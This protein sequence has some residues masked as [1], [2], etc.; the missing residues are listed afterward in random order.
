MTLEE[1]IK[2]CERQSYEHSKCAEEHK[3]L[4]EWLKELQELKQ[5]NCDNTDKTLKD[6]CSNT[7]K[8]LKRYPLC[9]DCIKKGRGGHCRKPDDVDCSD[10]EDEEEYK[11]K[12]RA[13]WRT[14]EPK[15]TLIGGITL[16]RVMTKEKDGWDEI[17]I[18][19]PDRHIDWTFD[20]ITPKMR[21]RVIELSQQKWIDSHI[22]PYANFF[23][24]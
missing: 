10:Y 24:C 2:H 1:A 23:I 22:P 20:G 19:Y 17:A 13:Q 14:K 6:N 16:F 7:D 18:I 3:Q 21:E 11:Q 15:L 9:K 8:T 5:G 4:A 12:R